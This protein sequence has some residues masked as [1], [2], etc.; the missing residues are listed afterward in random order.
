MELTPICAQIFA[1][2]VFLPDITQQTREQTQVNRVVTGIGFVFFAAH[3]RQHLVQLR[4]N[5]VP[6]TQ[7]H[8]RQELFLAQVA[9]F[10]LR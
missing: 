7:A 4:V 9:E 2:F 6:F 1:F 8:I 5:V 10:A 3:F